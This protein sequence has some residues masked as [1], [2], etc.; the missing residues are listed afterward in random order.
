MIKI[1]RSACREFAKQISQMELTIRQMID[2]LGTA[3]DHIIN[4]SDQIVSIITDKMLCL[5]SGFICP[6]DRSELL[7]MGS[8]TYFGELRF[9]PIGESFRIYEESGEFDEK[10]FICPEG[11]SIMAIVGSGFEPSENDPNTLVSMNRGY[12]ALLRKNF[13]NDPFIQPQSIQIE[14]A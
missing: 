1:D 4:D 9:T 8:A 14:H 12:R 2:S 3:K 13:T 10:T 7:K 5:W 11:W 6:N